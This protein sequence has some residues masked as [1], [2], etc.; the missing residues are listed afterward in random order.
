[1]NGISGWLLKR[2]FNGNS[3]SMKAKS[4]MIISLYVNNDIIVIIITEIRDLRFE[5]LAYAVLS[6]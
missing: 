4:Q 3:R 6:Q 2:P 1:M 5:Q